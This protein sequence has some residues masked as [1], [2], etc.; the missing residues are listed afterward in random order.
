MNIK[1]YVFEQDYGNLKID[2][3]TFNELISK[4]KFSYYHS[5][6]FAYGN[7]IR[8]TKEMPDADKELLYMPQT[9]DKHR[10]AD[11]GGYIRGCI[12]ISKQKGILH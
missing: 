10:F 8:S 5:D 4:I 7:D 1:S 12:K 11:S 3:T 9:A 2:N 6:M